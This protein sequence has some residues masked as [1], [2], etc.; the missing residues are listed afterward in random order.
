MGIPFRTVLGPP[1]MKYSRFYN[2]LC[3]PKIFGYSTYAACLGILGTVVTLIDLRRLLNGEAPTCEGL[4]KNRLSRSERLS[5]SPH[6][7]CTLLRSGSKGLSQLRFMVFL[8]AVTNETARDLKL[9]SSVLGVEHYALLALGAFTDNPVL[10]LPWL[11]MGMV[12]IFLE[13]FLF[14]SRLFYEGI[15]MNRSEVLFTVMMI[16]NWLQV[17]C[18]FNR[19]VRMCDY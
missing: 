9:M 15:H 6:P 1:L 8:L 14:A 19:Q 17:F 13:A 2:R 7:S 3:S 4:W 16:H 5:I 18:L 12:V 11:F 10:L